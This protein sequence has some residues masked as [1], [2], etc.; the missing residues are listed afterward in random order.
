M[1]SGRRPQP[2]VMV[3]G[4]GGQVRFYGSGAGRKPRAKRWE[5]AEALIS[6]G[7]YCLALGL[8]NIDPQNVAW[9]ELSTGNW[10]RPELSTGK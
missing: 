6:G 4:N 2:K 7:Y 9:T 5:A 10:L 8:R 1:A 3:V